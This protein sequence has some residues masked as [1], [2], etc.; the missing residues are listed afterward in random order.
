MSLI[1]WCCSVSTKLSN[2]FQFSIFNVFSKSMLSF[3]HT[4]AHQVINEGLHD[5]MNKIKQRDIKSLRIYVL[6]THLYIRIEI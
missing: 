6:L 2:Q 3:S 4:H 5:L 1:K